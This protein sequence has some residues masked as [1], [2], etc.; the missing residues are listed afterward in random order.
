MVGS[1][2]TAGEDNVKEQAKPMNEHNKNLEKSGSTN[3][4]QNFFK[5]NIPLAIVIT[6]AFVIYQRATGP[7]YPKKFTLD[8]G[9]QSTRVK[10]LRSHGGET[11]API[12]IP[13]IGKHVSGTLTYRRYPTNDPWTT[14]NL[15]REKNILKSV[16]PHQ[17]PA[18]KLQ[19]F[20]KLNLNNGEIRDLGTAKEPIMI[21]YKGAVPTAVLAPHIF[22]MFLSML[23]AMLGALEAFKNTK[24][25]KKITYA[26]F[27]S[28]FIGGMIL[29]PVVQKYAFGVYWAGFPYDWDLTDNKLLIGVLAWLAA[30][31]FNWK[32]PNRSATIIAAIIL[33]G[34]YTIPHST[35]GSQYN[36]NKGQVETD[37]D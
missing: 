21:R 9:D 30:V 18:G 24:S 16:L 12:T 15:V 5:V 23:L 10:L 17:P 8:F 6:L 36:Y 3:M 31:L 14:V 7:T 37:V 19:Y 34:I 29:G 13:V 32:K 35:M 27:A 2:I 26:T 4:L 28:L 33:F 11:N 25:F 20:V 1:T 22:F